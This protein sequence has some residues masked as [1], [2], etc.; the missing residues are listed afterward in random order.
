MKRIR[1]LLSFMA[2]VVPSILGA[3]SLSPTLTVERVGTTGVNFKTTGLSPGAVSKVPGQEVILK[4]TCTN[5]DCTTVSVE[6]NGKAQKLTKVAGE[7][8]PLKLP[9]LAD[10]K[11][12]VLVEGSTSDPFSTT[13]EVDA[14]DGDAT[15]TTTGTKT[16]ALDELLQNPCTNVIGAVPTA[17]YS[18]AGNLISMIVAPTG[19]V[20]AAPVENM[21]EDD[22]LELWVLADSRLTPL[23]NA[24]RKSAIRTVGSL[25][26][27][28]AGVTIHFPEARQQG[29]TLGGLPPCEYRKFILNSFAPGRGEVE[30][31]VAQGAQPVVTGNFDFVVDRLYDGLFSFGAVRSDVVDRTFKLTPKGT[32]KIIYAS[33]DGDHQT[34]Y[35]VFYT[36]FL[37]GKRDIEKPVE[38][39]LHR[40]NPTFGFSVNNFADNA[41]VG[42]SYDFA[43]GFV[44][45]GGVHFSR[46]KALSGRSGLKEGSPFTGLEA[47]IPTEKGWE[48][49]IF[50]GASIDLRAASQLL[51]T[52][53]GTGASTP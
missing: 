50:V 28:G 7:D 10:N 43:R 4:I 21:D 9:N 51:Q 33:E 30:I 26:I 42:L 35:A 45:L 8:V 44:L 31:S 27:V 19:R 17:G 41:L 12:R 23:L 6:L 20:I 18:R 48:Q 34:L 22:V 52:V 46:V 25:Q 14:S 36:P 49:G 39:P 47:E 53:F 5:L 11:L 2:F 29:G 16:A 38:N 3:E 15:G 24:K 32:E 1:L 40:L 37:W 13:I